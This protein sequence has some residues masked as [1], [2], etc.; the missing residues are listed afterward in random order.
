MLKYAS[1][2]QALAELEAR[3][4]GEVLEMGAERMIVAEAF[5]FDLLQ[6]EVSSSLTWSTLYLV[7][8]SPPISRLNY[9]VV[10][11]QFSYCLV[12]CLQLLNSYSKLSLSVTNSTAIVLLV[13]G[14]YWR[15]ILRELAPPPLVVM[16]TCM[17]R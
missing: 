14:S 10:S 2:S 3:W 8:A 13:L 4:K 7:L 16:K 6:Q 1:S 12:T 9:C 11:S 17:Y 15:E 5:F